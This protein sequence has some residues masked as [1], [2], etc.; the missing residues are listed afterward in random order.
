MLARGGGTD[1]HSRDLGGMWAA[2]RDHDTDQHFA[3]VAGW[4]DTTDL[5]DLHRRR[6]AAYRDRLCELWPPERSPAAAAY[7]ARL[8]RLLDDLTETY[9]AAAA[10]YATFATVATALVQARA[11]IEPLHRRHQ[12]LHAVVTPSPTPGPAPGGGVPA[13]VPVAA[14]E[15][16]EQERLTRQGRSIMIE[17]SGTLVSAESALRI[18]RAYD[19]GG[20]TDPAGSAGRLGSGGSAGPPA[21]GGGPVAG[22]GLAVVAG[23]AAGGGPSTAGGGGPGAGVAVSAAGVGPRADGSGASGPG[24]GGPVLSASVP[25]GVTLPPGRTAPP[26]SGAVPPFGEAGSPGG[27]APGVPPGQ[28]AGPGKGLVPGVIAGPGAPGARGEPSMPPGQRDLGQREAA[29]PVAPRGGV[30]GGAVLPSGAVIGAGPGGGIVGQ[31]PFMPPGRPGAAGAAGGQAGSVQESAGLRLAPDVPWAAAE[32][33]APVIHPSV[34][35]GPIDPGPVI[36]RL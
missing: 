27:S 22:P 28:V 4:R 9:E 12:Q 21:D 33:V 36:G 25:G 30:P 18:P 8:D 6:V 16:A 29:R 26:V 14:P 11:R 20:G 31:V 2:L 23:A 3:T 35:P 34:A 19:G 1:W 32:G 24:S 13:T 17:L 7:V 15:S 5:I 10:N